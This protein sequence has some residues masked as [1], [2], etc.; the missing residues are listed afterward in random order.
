MRQ[1]PRNQLR[2]L[3]PAGTMEGVIAWI[4]MMVVLPFPNRGGD[5]SKIISSTR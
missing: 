2:A 5:R 4:E 3:T 1:L